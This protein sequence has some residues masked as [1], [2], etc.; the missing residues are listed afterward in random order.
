MKTKGVLLILS[1]AIISGFAI[2]IGKFGVSVINPYIFTA[3]KNIVVVII[4]CSLLLSIK[5][6]KSLKSLSKKNWILLLIIG[7][8]GGSIPFLLFFKGLSLTTAV[9]GSFIHKTMFIYI[10]VFAAIFLKEKISKKFLIGG[11]FLLLGNVFLLRLIPGSL[12]IGDLLILIATFFWAAENVISKHTLKELSPRI[13]IWGRMFFGSIFILLFLI[14]TNQI[15]LIST[16]NISQIIWTIV[17]GVI[18]FGYVIT[19]YTGLKY[20]PVSLAALILLLGSSITTLLSLV[21][22]GTIDFTQILGTTFIF[23]GII[24]ITTTLYFF[25]KNSCLELK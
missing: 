6:W 20:I 11:L 8:I 19:W 18:L 9:Q 22:V 24:I 16:I 10:A 1:T 4:I 2:F 25:R 15:Y 21:Q 12:G 14:I 5:E 3:L 23:L 17:T 13:V 7:L